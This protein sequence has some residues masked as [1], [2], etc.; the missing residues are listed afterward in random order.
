MV[1]FR[2]GCCSLVLRTIDRMAERALRAPRYLSDRSKRPSSCPYGILGLGEVYR[3]YPQLDGTL[4]FIRSTNFSQNGV[5]W[6][7]KGDRNAMK[8]VSKCSCKAGSS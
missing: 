8:A 2:V 5:G 4:P 6:G 3:I 1:Y 7:R